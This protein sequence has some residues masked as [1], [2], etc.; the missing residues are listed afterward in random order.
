LAKDILT[1]LAEEKFEGVWQPQLEF[2]IYNI[3]GRAEL[4][5][6]KTHSRLN[7]FLMK[8]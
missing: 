6:L 1:L 7:P 5:I 3:S 2:P 8:L 4:K